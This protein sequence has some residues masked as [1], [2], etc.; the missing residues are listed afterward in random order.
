M[1]EIKPIQN[2]NEQEIIC[3]LCGIEFDIDT[4]AYGAY[5]SGKLIGAAQFR[6]RGSS[7]YLYDIKNTLDCDDK[8][9]LFIMGRAVLNYI[10]LHGVHEA[11]FENPSYQDMELI[12]KIGFR[13]C[14]DGKLYMNLEGFFESP[15]QHDKK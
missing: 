8:D 2:K 15:C 3:K 1:L 13:P 5:I 14:E 9:A 6:I 4:L 10:D 7:G 11:Y 12:K